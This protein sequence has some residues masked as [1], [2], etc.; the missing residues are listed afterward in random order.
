MTHLKNGQETNKKEMNMTRLDYN[1]DNYFDT[2]GRGTRYNIIGDGQIIYKDVSENEVDRLY[3]SI[4]PY[5]YDNIVCVE[6]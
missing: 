4:A 3:D 1:E 5:L 2:Q 6:V